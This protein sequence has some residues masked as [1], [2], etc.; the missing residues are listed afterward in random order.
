M[1]PHIHSVSVVLDYSNIGTAC[2]NPA[3][4]INVV[5]VRLIPQSKES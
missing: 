4:L 1:L 5:P 2:L 3:L